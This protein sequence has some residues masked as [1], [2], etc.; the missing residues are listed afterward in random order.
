[1]T[2]T[3]YKN[4]NN[5]DAELAWNDQNTL[6]ISDEARVL[7]D[8]KTSLLLMQERRL[9]QLEEINQKLVSERDTFKRHCQS[10]ARKIKS[11]E[12]RCAAIEQ[13]TVALDDL[14]KIDAAEFLP[15]VDRPE[16]E[17]TMQRLMRKSGD[18]VKGTAAVSYTHLTLPTNREV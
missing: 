11:L 2:I 16:K 14:P 15:L 13:P 9:S 1:M 17:T 8:D 4:K 12:A 5:I 18:L 3:A 10:L 6:D 7:R